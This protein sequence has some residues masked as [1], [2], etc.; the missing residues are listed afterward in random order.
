MTFPK[1]TFEIDGSTMSVVDVGSGPAVL[2][3]HGWLCDASMWDAQIRAFVSRYRV[4]VPEMWGHGESAAMPNTAEVMRDLAR[5]HCNLLDQLEVEKAAIIGLSLG[6][7][8][9]A[10]LALIAPARV[11]SLALLATSL[12]AEPP[13]SRAEF[14]AGVE[15]MADRGA[16][17]SDLADA[18]VS[19]LYSADFSA[20]EPAVVAAH[21]ARLTA[22]EPERIADSVAPIGR[23]IF[24]RRDALADLQGLSMPVL[25]IAG[26]EDRALPK[27]RVEQMAERI[28]SAFTEVPGAGHMLTYEAPAFLN[29]ALLAFLASAP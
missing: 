29:E 13:K 12:A 26:A 5:Q 25:T 14:L 7:M 21:R 1:K 23:I 11:S 18:L 15:D 24:N 16:V 2:L 19:L 22:W 28:G 3:A 20:A 8:W 17:S 6:G 27:A 9:G 10:E 4:I